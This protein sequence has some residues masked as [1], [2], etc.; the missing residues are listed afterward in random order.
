[1]KISIRKV[2]NVTLA[3]V[4]ALLTAMLTYMVTKFYVNSTFETLG[5]ANTERLQLVSQKADALVTGS[6]AVARLLYQ[7]ENIIGTILSSSVTPQNEVTISA[8]IDLLCTKYYS[9]FQQFDLTFDV[10]CFGVNG[11]QYSSC[12]Y[13]DAE[14]NQLSSYSWFTKQRAMGVTDYSVTNFVPFPKDGGKTYC[15]AIVRNLY[16]VR[17]SYAG[18]IIVFVKED[19]F[20]SVYENLMQ[21]NA[22]FYLLNEYSTVISSSDASQTGTS[23]EAIRDYLFVRGNDSYATYTNDAGMECFCAKYTS[24][25]TGWTMFEQIPLSE[26]MNPIRKATYVIITIAAGLY[27]LSVFVISFVSESIS[28]PIQA[29]CREMESSVS[30]HFTHLKVETKISE[31]RSIGISYNHLCDE[32][33]KL[34]EDVRAAEK[35]ANDAKFDFLKAQINPHFLYNTLFSVKCTIAMK[36]PEHACEM[37]SLLISVLQNTVSSNKSDNTL[38]EE[39]ILIQQ[40]V[41]LQNLRY[42]NKIRFRMDLPRELMDKTIPRFLIQP[43]VENVFLHAIPL[44]GEEV[45]LLIRFRSSGRDL[46]IETCDTGIGFTQAE[47]EAVMQQPFSKSSHIGLKNIQDRVHLLYGDGF[48]LSVTGNDYFHTIIMLRLPQQEGEENDVSHIGS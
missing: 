32:I 10:V 28:R 8:N 15:Y 29:V 19:V 6:E 40:Y 39:T 12:D 42:D 45:E 3:L 33:S 43:L 11:F 1:M 13:S 18:S 21:E 26:V 23:P 37:L 36:E 25:I 41:R 16:Q 20:Q 27:L 14:F 46:L 35:Q 44:T 2:L 9:A 48:G 24:P 38:L 22:T 17:G 31:I 30:R 7:D 5:R 47:M 4:L 34:L